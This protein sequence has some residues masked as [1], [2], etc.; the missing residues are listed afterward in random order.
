MC[1]QAHVHYACGCVQSITTRSCSGSLQAAKKGLRHKV[2]TTNRYLDETCPWECRNSTFVGGV[3]DRLEALPETKS[4]STIVPPPQS[5]FMETAVSP[6]G[7]E[8]VEQ[9][10]AAGGTEN[11][12]QG[13]ESLLKLCYPSDIHRLTTGGAVTED[14]GEVSL[15]LQHSSVNEDARE[16]S[17]AFQHHRPGDTVSSHPRG[18]HSGTEPLVNPVHELG[19]VQPDVEKIEDKD[20]E[21]R[22]ECG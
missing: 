2:T 10:A 19:I 18:S 14:A 13:S 12:S 5:A 15:A 8:N 21:H 9:A 16:I 20:C 6:L 11:P 1:F 4:I 3:G 7:N 22:D 17:P